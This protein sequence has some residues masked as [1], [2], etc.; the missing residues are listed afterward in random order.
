M[1]RGTGSGQ[2]PETPARELGWKPVG[3]LALI[4]LPSGD[5]E[6]RVAGRKR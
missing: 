3:V 1:K 2:E 6:R 4:A 5:A